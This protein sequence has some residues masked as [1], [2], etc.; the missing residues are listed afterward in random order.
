MSVDQEMKV[1]KDVKAAQPLVPVAPNVTTE[2]PAAGVT[3]EAAN[4]AAIA[5]AQAQ[6]SPPVVEAPTTP[7]PLAPMAVAAVAAAATIPTPKVPVEEVKDLSAW[8]D[9]DERALM[10]FITDAKN[11]K[12]KAA[13][14]EAASSTDAA[15]G[16]G[17][18][19]N[20]D[21]VTDEAD[22][23]LLSDGDVAAWEEISFRFPGRTAINCLQR[24]TRIQLS[25]AKAEAVAARAET[26]QARAREILAVSEN[27]TGG[28][29]GIAGAGAG[30]EAGA[31]AAAGGIPPMPALGGSGHPALG[32]KRPVDGDIGVNGEGPDAKKV[33]SEVTLWTEEETKMLR[34]MVS[35]FPNSTP[36]WND[37][38]AT[39]PSKTPFE[40]LQKWNTM[41]KPPVI[42]GK[43][44]WTQEEDNILRDKRAL[45]G[46]KWA[47]IAS[48]LPGRQGKQCRERYVN[49]L[50]PNLKK[51]E[52]T[53]DEEAILIALH[54]HHG[55]RWANIAKQLPGRSDND[56]KNHWYSTIQRK[57]QTHG[58]EKLISAAI[59]QVQL[60]VNKQGTIVTPQ[61][62][63]TPVPGT[64]PGP[65]YT[66]QT[67]PS[68]AAA[69]TVTGTVP[70]PYNPYGN[71]FANS[72]M[73]GLVY[74]PA[75]SFLNTAP[76]LQVPAGD[77]DG[78]KVKGES[79]ET[80]ATVEENSAEG[81]APSKSEA[82]DGGAAPTS[83]E[84]GDG[85]TKDAEMVKEKD[86][87]AVEGEEVEVEV[88]TKEKKNVGKADDDASEKKAVEDNDD[89]PVPPLEPMAVDK[90]T[91]VFEIE[92]G[93][94]EDADSAIMGGNKVDNSESEAAAAIE[95]DAIVIEKD[96]DASKGGEVIE[97][98]DTGT[99]ED[100]GTNDEVETGEVH[101]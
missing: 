6:A 45:Y 18:D 35:Q 13:G 2:T 22:L 79:K 34:E 30:V 93:K 44:S 61:G 27:S 87:G 16:N 4:T 71:N 25:Q 38:A 96:A 82:G 56:I 21:K 78:A 85:I 62:F 75:G 39:F 65:T 51:G 53:D 77:G 36:R 32:V 29:T 60:M 69:V 3:T 101:V 20:A 63:P 37:I 88:K 94:T 1:V 8:T 50:D 49:H 89:E 91:E 47:K 46:R 7:A 86:N 84:N 28:S 26:A 59:Q 73:P 100:Q 10:L 57:F 23:D 11:S 95:N 97:S 12:A 54:E 68:A 64:V 24:Y 66:Q 98:A 70:G 52:W 74:P 40:C 99:A 92:N 58:R 17:T 55:N 15:T 81:A 19:T 90:T 41:S 9:T 5:P 43:G 67:N 31:G 14:V 76:F 72:T 33:R 48:H 83:A 80:T 42:K